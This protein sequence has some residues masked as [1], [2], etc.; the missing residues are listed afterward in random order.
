LDNE[1]LGQHLCNNL[2]IDMIIHASEY[3]EDPEMEAVPRGEG[4]YDTEQPS[5]HCR[6]EDCVFRIPALLSS[7][8]LNEGLPL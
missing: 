6:W 1:H 5:G 8:L 2:G 3:V 4:F 7:F